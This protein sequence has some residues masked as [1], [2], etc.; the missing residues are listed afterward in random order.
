MPGQT[1]FSVLRVSASGGGHFDVTL[2]IRPK[3]EIHCGTM[4]RVGTDSIDFQRVIGERP[5]SDCRRSYGVRRLG[6]AEG[7]GQSRGVPE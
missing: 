4:A 3:L 2:S 7:R 5:C 1:R 6:L